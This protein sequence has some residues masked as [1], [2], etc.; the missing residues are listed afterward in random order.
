MSLPVPIILNA[1]AGVSVQANDDM[2]QRLHALFQSMGLHPCIALARSGGE[3][4]SLAQRAVQARSHVVVA[5]GG[6]GTLNAVASALVGTDVALGVLPLGTLNHFAKDLRIPLDLK[7]AVH[8]IHEGCTVHVDVGEVNGHVFLNN[9]SLGLYPRLVRHRKKQQEQLGRGKWPAFLWAAFTILR[10]YP[11][12]HVR[13]HLEEKELVRRTPFVFIGNNEYQLDLFN[14]GARVCLD[15][16]ALSLYVTHRTGRLGLL[17][18]ALRALIGRLHN[19]KDFDRW[20]VKELRIE[21]RPTR[22]LVA[23]DGEVSVME[24]PLQYRIRP[25]ALRVIVPKVLQPA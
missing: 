8:T 23:T 3:I 14:I 10:R 15:A 2:C 7:S 21:T 16:G 25:G 22:L 18:L 4:S 1:L 13:L 5:A 11:F 6:D 12:L 9:S 17:T 19:T 24:T 20:C